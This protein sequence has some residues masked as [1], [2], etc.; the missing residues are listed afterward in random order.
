MIVPNVAL[1]HQMFGD[2]EDYG[3][4]YVADKCHLIHAGQ[5]KVFN[6]PVIISTWQSTYKDISLFRQFDVL[7]CDEAH[8]AKG[9]SIQSISAACSEA[10]YKIG[11]SGTYPDYKTPEWFS[12]VGS[13][14]PIVEYNTYKSLQN[15]G[16]I[17]QLK[18]YAIILEYNQAYRYQVYEQSHKDYNK[19]L[20]IIHSNS[21]RNEVLLKMAQNFK[22][23]SLFLFT[24]I[25]KHGLP[26]RDLFKE[27]LK[28]KT[29]L[30]I[31]GSVDVKERELFRKMIETRDDI[32]LLASYGTFAVGNNVK[33]LHHLVFASG[34]KSMIKV[35]QSLGRG[36][37]KAE[38]KTHLTLYDIIDNLKFKHSGISYENFSMK[39][40]KERV[41]IYEKEGFV[42]NVK[43]IKL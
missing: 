37:R 10:T 24:K 32:V 28:E 14:G 41:K 6:C 8:T 17:A 22:G 2:F 39:H 19:E 13:L 43:K 21:A 29:L 11:C 7:I 4:E 33:N 38:G 30:Y 42:W 27:R 1:V 16:H 26:L 12:I 20:D 34:Y 35:L 40:F 31:D 3:W 36:I 9:K 18:I 15:A 25:E 5:K 23:N